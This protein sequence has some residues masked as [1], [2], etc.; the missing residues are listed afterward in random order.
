M[1]SVQ[2]FTCPHCGA[3]QEVRSSLR[4]GDSFECE[5]CGRKIVFGAEE[6]SKPTISTQV[7]GQLWEESLS[8]NNSPNDTIKEAR[9]AERSLEG[10][11]IQR[12]DVLPEREDQEE[13]ADYKLEELIGRGGMGVVYKAHQFSMDR[14][15]AVKMIHSEAADDSHNRAKFLSEAAVTGNLD[16]PNIVPIHD[17]GSDEKGQLFYAMKEVKGRSWREVIEENGV[18]ENVDILLD[19]CDAVAFAHSKGVIHRDI[20]PENVML[21]EYGEVLLMDW[22]L[23]ASTGEGGKG[24]SLNG[25]VS[26]AGTPSYMAPEM[27]RG[28]GDSIGFHSDQYLLGAILFQIVTG[29]RP[30]PGESTIECI[31]N[32]GNNVI[33]ETDQTGELV[34][35]AM[36]AMATDPKDRYESVQ[37]FQNALQQYGKHLESV[38]LGQQART[39]LEKAKESGSYDDYAAAAFGFKQA[40]ELWAGN[41]RAAAGIVEAEVAYAKCA[42]RHG[43]LDLAGSLL[44]E[45]EPSHADLIE[46]V[47]VLRKRRDGRRKTVRLLS[48]ASVTLVAIVIV[49]LA[50]AFFWVREERNAAIAAKAKEIR[51]RQQTELARDK[52]EI[53]RKK[54]VQARQETLANARKASER[55]CKQALRMINEGR[56]KEAQHRAE[57]ALLVCKQAPFGWYAQARVAQAKNSHEKAIE[58]FEKSL[59]VNPNY[60]DSEI[61]MVR[62]KEALGRLAAAEVDVKLSELID[63]EGLE[64]EED[65]YVDG[66]DTVQDW[67]NL[68]EYA[69]AAFSAG[70]YEKAYETYKRTLKVMEKEGALAYQIQEC[71]SRIQ[72]SHVKNLCDSWYAERDKQTG[73]EKAEAVIG[74]LRECNGEI[75][76]WEYE[77][78]GNRLVSMQANEGDSLRWLEPLRGLELTS[79]SLVACPHL[80]DLSPLRGMPLQ[81]LHLEKVSVSDISALKGMPLKQLRLG[82]SPVSDISALKGLSLM[83]FKLWNT[84][85]RDISPLSG[86]PLTQLRLRQNYIN[87]IR[88]LNGLPLKTLEFTYNRDPEVTDLS[89]LKGM[90][91]TELN[92]C[93]N[94]IADLQPLKG[95]PLTDLNLCGNNVTDLTPLRGMPLESLNIALTGVSS[96]TPLRGMPLKSLNLYDTNVTD[97]SVL[98]DMPLEWLNLGRTEVRD[99]SPLKRTQLQKL[100]LPSDRE[101]VEVLRAIDTLKAIGIAKGYL[102]ITWQSADEFWANRKAREALEE[103]VYEDSVH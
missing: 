41:E 2:K 73:K 8:E 7:I 36:K 21:G 47:E 54:A 66:V 20:K 24:E 70:R 83:D 5:D 11:T 17:L 92:L 85:V 13:Y 28:L 95:M 23:A 89:P 35:I 10:V 63:E 69:D 4:T 100:A 52:A 25:K 58:L 78:D 27:A 57:D 82:D 34:H 88:A 37:E 43:D 64:A 87:D 45:E 29:K 72:K 75:G 97:I 26:T 101:G 59:E 76:E 81:K 67:K 77:V 51:S 93:G 84:G 14:E 94:S 42:L 33:Q 55:F 99:M 71:K 96:L 46:R 98:E 102:S 9:R 40:V 68:K 15:V 44:R 80:S 62:S 74:K 61:A 1:E 18:Q 32:A 65:S 86:M 91:L 12:R 39:Q 22:G 19:V 31:R 48:Y 50:V 103:G 53:A 30:H 16:H 3:Q 38:R 6:L 90:R 49:I 60:K 79:L 56:L